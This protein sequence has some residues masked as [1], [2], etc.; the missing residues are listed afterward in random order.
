MAG[1][2]VNQRTGQYY[3]LP[4]DADHERL[5]QTGVDERS[6]RD[7][8]SRIKGHAL[9]FIDTCYAGNVI[10]NPRTAGRELSRL[11]SELAAAENGVIVFA[12]STGL[13]TSE[14]SDA[15]SNGAFTKAL[16]SGLSGG[17]DLNRSGRIT[18]KGLDFY[19]SE[20]VSRLTKG[21]QTPV[22]IAPVGIP[23]FVLARP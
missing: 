5:A 14:E 20:E 23:D 18:Y 10:G 3:F 19:V 15:W 12:S 13:Q 1:H 4:V 16:L 8:L 2:G 17:A 21:R 9:F 7:A 11:V 6:I 22:T